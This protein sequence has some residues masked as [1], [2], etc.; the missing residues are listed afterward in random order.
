[1]YS[2]DTT[3]TQKGSRSA[4]PLYVLPLNGSFD[5]Y[6]LLFPVSVVAYLPVMECPLKGGSPPTPFRHVCAPI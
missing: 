1:M 2:D 3:L 4:Y 5:L 6:K